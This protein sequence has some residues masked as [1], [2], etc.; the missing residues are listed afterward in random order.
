MKA[1]EAFLLLKFSQ[2]VDT[3]KKV[4]RLYIRVKKFRRE[5]GNVVKYAYLV[6]NKWKKR[7]TKTGKKGARQKVKGYLGKVHDCVRCNEKDFIS[8]FSVSDVKAHFGEKGVNEVIKDLI[9]LELLNHGFSE[10]GDFYVNGDLMVYCGE[11][12]FIKNVKDEKDRK[13]VLCMNEGFLCKETFDKLIGFKA[14]GTEKEIGLDLAN[15]LLEAGLKVPNE[16]FVEMF[17]RVSK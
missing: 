7:G 17:E 6:E 15:A 9:R 11:E 4:F 3:T 8:H 1:A 10:N 12:F 13:I 2:V 14:R 16:V 5:N